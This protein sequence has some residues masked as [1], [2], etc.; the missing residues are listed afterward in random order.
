M[1]KAWKK[2]DELHLVI[3]VLWIF[4]GILVFVNVILCIG[5]MHAPKKMRIYIPP[6]LSSGAL[7]NPNE[8]PKAS[9]YA[10][11]FQI[12]TAVNSWPESGAQDYAKNLNSYRNYLSSSFYYALLRDLKSRQENGELN[13]HRIMSAATAMPYSEVDVKK[14]GNGVWLVNLHLQLIETLDG[15]VIKNVVMDYPLQV[16]SIHTS[17]QLNPWGLVL[18]GYHGKS[19]RVK[20]EDPRF[21]SRSPS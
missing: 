3:K 17:I 21:A 10:F 11:A 18:T 9:I 19:F 4:I 6:D 16:A 12:F 13:R 15:S 5:W 7:I 8:I 14:L 20:T 2:F 1:F